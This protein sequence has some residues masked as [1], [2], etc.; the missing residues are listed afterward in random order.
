MDIEKVKGPISLLYALPTEL[1]FMILGDCIASGHPEFMR[2]SRALERDGQAVICKEGVYRMRFGARIDDK[3]QR[4]S[5]EVA[6]AIQNL[7]ITIDLMK[8]DW[9]KIIFDLENSS[10][11]NRFWAA[12]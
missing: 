10:P 1:R 12:R 5:Q 11:A 9:A 8:I 7:E 4:P 6:N 3:G 2:A